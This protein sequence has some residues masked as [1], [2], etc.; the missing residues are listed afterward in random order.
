MLKPRLKRKSENACEGNVIRLR[1]MAATYSLTGANNPATMPYLCF[2]PNFI[3]RQLIYNL[4]EEHLASKGI[5]TIEHSD[6]EGCERLFKFLG[7]DIVSTFDNPDKVVLG[8]CKLIEEVNPALLNVIAP[9]ICPSQVM[10]G[11]DKVVRFSGGK[12]GEACTIVLRL[13]VR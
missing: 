11:E 8:E 9:L 3:Q 10:I 2:S 12:G 7:G 13:V 4:P 1:V 5:M 6:F